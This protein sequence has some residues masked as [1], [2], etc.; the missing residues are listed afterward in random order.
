M[1]VEG[2]DGRSALEEREN[3]ET[4]LTF[5]NNAAWA[6]RTTQRRCGI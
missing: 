5:L 1:F 2:L 3:I 6:F 4:A